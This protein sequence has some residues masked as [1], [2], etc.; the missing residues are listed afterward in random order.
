MSGT[1]VVN[2]PGVFLVDEDGNTATVAD[3]DTIGSAEALLVAG[4][5]GTVA[6]I[7]AVDATG[8]L[9]IQNSPNLD[10]AL[11]TLA[12]ETKLEAVRALLSTIDA[13]TG[14][15]ASVDFATETKL[16]AVRL[17]LA[18]IDG[19]DFATE[20]TMA[21]IKDTDGIKKI[22]DGVQLNAGS[23]EI[24]AV[25]QGTKASPSNAWPVLIT[26]SA[27]NPV[28]VSEDASIYRLEV[29]GKVQTI[30]AISPPSTNTARINA[31]APLTAGSHDTSFVIPNG[32]TYHLQQI[33]AGNEDP[34]KG[35]VFEIIYDDGT[36][37]VIA[38]VYTAGQTISVGYSDLVQA[39]DGTPLTGNGSN[40]IIVRRVK[41]AGSNIAMDCEVLGY[42]V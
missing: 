16:E 20:T 10:V 24:G 11:S 6:R 35:A 42:T 32:E 14:T 37:H 41:F 25:A 38:R 34:T 36:E 12:T 1:I 30:G 19:K 40:S 33:T 17:L 13:D 9:A 29:Q 31:D 28:T 27:G 3:G 7:L 2:Q 39:R 23:A 26:S 15:I 22:T 8:K 18:S 21:A 5:D 4:A